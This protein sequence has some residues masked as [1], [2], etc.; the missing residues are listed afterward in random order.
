[1]ASKKTK[2][3]MDFLLEELKKNKHAEYRD[4][5]EKADKKRVTIYPI[6]FG[7]AK[8]LLGLVK[9]AP[10]G[11]GKARKKAAAKRGPGRPRKHAPRTA[12]RRS[13][14]GDAAAAVQELVGM[15]NA[16]SKENAQL[17]ATLERVREMID[18]VL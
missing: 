17:R 2:A 16:T 11:Q 3:G 6:M 9:T 8:S 4:L 5:K 13:S 12:A 14:G 18:R 10:R 7:R 1:M 15:M